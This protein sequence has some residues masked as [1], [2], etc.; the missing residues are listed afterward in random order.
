MKNET[1]LKKLKHLFN[2]NQESAFQINSIHPIS[3]FIFDFD[4]VLVKECD[5]IETAYGWIIRAVREKN[6]DTKDLFINQNDLEQAFFIRPI[7]KAKSQAEKITILNEKY[8][9]LNLT[10]DHIEEL[11]ILWTKEVF[12]NLILNQFGDNPK[13]YLLAGAKNFLEK[14]SHIGKVFGLT[15]NIQPQAEFLMEFVGLTEY[16]SEIVGFPVEIS[17]NIKLNKTKMLQ[18]LML[19]QGL[20][21][22]ETCYIGDSTP[23]IR[24][25]QGAG[26]LTIGIANNY[27]NGAELIEQGCDIIATST[28]AYSDVLTILKTK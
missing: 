14:T 9:N 2:N 23:D 18:N 12:T 22:K 21:V 6:F 1:P 27:S 5:I 25:G 3:N 17:Q 19:K 24:A 16:F 26:I 7:V 10:K 4:G 8:G 20:H 15:A 28:A 13:E 11:I